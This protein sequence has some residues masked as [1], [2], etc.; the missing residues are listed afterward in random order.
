MKYEVGNQVFEGWKIV[1]ELGQGASGK[2]FELQKDDFHIVTKSA[3][4]I[5][6]V[7]SSKSAIDSVM[8]EGMD[9]QSVTSYFKSFVDEIVREIAIMSELKSHPNIVRYEDHQVICHQEDVGWDILIRMELLTPVTEY[10]RCSN[11]N[12]ETVLRMAKELVGV[13]SYC[14]SKHL[15]HRDVK[16][17][18]VFVDG[19]G[20]FKLGDFGV[21]RTVEK[22]TGGLS[23][24]GTESFMAP[25]VYLGKAYGANVDLYSLGLMLYQYLNNNRMP[26]FPLDRPITFSDRENAISRRM[27]GEALPAPIH[28]SEQFAK[29]ILKACAFEPKDRYQSAAEMTGALEQILLTKETKKEECN[30]WQKQ[31]MDAEKSPMN[32]EETIG[33]Y[34]NPD[35]E[36]TVGMYGNPNEEETV[37]MYDNPNEEETVGMYEK[38]GEEEETV[39]M[40]GNSSA[41]EGG[42]KEDHASADFDAS[43][44]ISLV[45][46]VK[47]CEKKV[48]IDG[49]TIEVKIPAG[50][51]DQMKLRIWLAEEDGNKRELYVRILVENKSVFERVNNNIYSKISI[52]DYLARSGGEVSVPTLYGP[53]KYWIAP[54]TMNGTRSCI[55]GKGVP[56][57]RNKNKVGDH[58]VSWY[59]QKSQTKSETGEGDGAAKQEKRA[60]KTSLKG[61]FICYSGFAII[62]AINI[63]NFIFR[64][65]NGSSEFSISMAKLELVISVIMLLGMASFCFYLFKKR[66]AAAMFV[67]FSCAAIWILFVYEELVMSVN[68][69]MWGYI[70]VA[71]WLFFNLYISHRVYKSLVDEKR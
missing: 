56:S 58:Y 12:E 16:P 33:M 69:D 42:A 31:A 47:G 64:I 13:L 60:G 23:K 32:E 49:K 25:E 27:S 66:K 63:P 61:P 35:E 59:V 28:A 26:F 37:G 14:H 29:V 17:Q 68:S 30:S 34:S 67:I 20:R 52:P 4:K 44:T 48:Y 5:I 43:V 18:N 21:A 54:G 71:F 36:E 62:M 22:T 2:V 46:A 53:V 8:S 50:I 1:K 19:L 40:Y 10:Q 51:D 70:C 57:L 45:E 7:P 9:E 38:T 24:K 39:G 3:L 15:I 41:E 65:Q 11:L 55:K 6:Q